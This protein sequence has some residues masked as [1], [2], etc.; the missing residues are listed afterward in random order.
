MKV[1]VEIMSQLMFCVLIRMYM[2]SIHYHR[3]STIMN[4]LVHIPMS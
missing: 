4:T 1:V 2:Y 3:N